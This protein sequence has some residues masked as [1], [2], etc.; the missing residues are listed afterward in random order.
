MRG[1]NRVRW[2]YELLV[3]AT[4]LVYTELSLRMRGL[5][6]TCRAFGVVLQ[7]DGNA[8]SK[9]CAALPIRFN[10]VARSVQR[11]VRSWPLG[12]TCLRRCVLLGWRI[13]SLG[14]V[15]KIG[16]RMDDSVLVAH[17]W[18]ELDGCPLDRESARYAP[19]GALDGSVH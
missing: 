2:I 5:T 17:S 1:S 19:L 10:M 4:L 12:D 3:S 18:L 6:K 7:L 16:I 14:P 11:I 9:E 8:S 15:L 13:N